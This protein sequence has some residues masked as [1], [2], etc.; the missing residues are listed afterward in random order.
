M[1]ASGLP[2]PVRRFLEVTYPDIVPEPATLAVD[3]VGRLRFGRLPWLPMQTRVSLVPG[4]DRVMDIRVRLGPITILH[5]LDAYVDERGF[6]KAIGA[7]VV[8][9]EVDEGAFHTLIL[10]SLALPHSWSRLGFAWD[11]V[12]DHTA[13][14]QVPF[15]GGVQTAIVRFDP[16]TGFPSVFEIPAQGRPRPRST[17]G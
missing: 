11:P 7:P 3:A 15:E 17:G 2:A 10:E 1:D 16:D 9:D 8:G 12:D 4:S 13:T 5:G 6:T 14:L